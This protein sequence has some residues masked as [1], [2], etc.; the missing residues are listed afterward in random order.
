MTASVDKR[1]RSREE[2]NNNDFMPLSKRINNL[3]LNSH[4]QQHHQFLINGFI[5]N[6]HQQNINSNN[7]TRN[8]HQ[9]QAQISNEILEEYKPDLDSTQNPHYYNSNRLLYELYVE[10]MRRTN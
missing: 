1:K 9:Q 7:E 10:R 6:H 4:H 3:H 8:N 2:D 5:D